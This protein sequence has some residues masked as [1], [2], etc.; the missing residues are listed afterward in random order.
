[1]TIPFHHIRKVTA[2]LFA[3][4]AISFIGFYATNAAAAPGNSINYS[5]QIQYTECGNPIQFIELSD[6]S[7]SLTE[8]S[9]VSF[10]PKAN[11]LSTFDAFSAALFTNDGLNVSRFLHHTFYTVVNIN[12]P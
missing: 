5:T 1:M 9:K 8:L 2:I 10:V 11:E 12:A 4:M 3:T 6:H 7:I